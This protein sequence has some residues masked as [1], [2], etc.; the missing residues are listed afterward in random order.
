MTAASL[1]EPM[2]QTEVVAE[3]MAESGFGLLKGLLF[4]LGLHAL[5]ALP[6]LLLLY[7]VP[8]PTPNERLAVEL[9]GMVSNRQT[10][11]KQLGEQVD[12][13]AAEPQKASATQRKSLPVVKQST[14][15]SPVQVDKQDDKPEVQ[16]Q[17]QVTSSYQGADEQQ[18][19]QTI[20][21][22]DLEMDALRKYAAAATKAIK[23][24]LVYPP[25][26]RQAGHSGMTIITFRVGLDGEIEAGTLVV[27][28]SSGYAS[29]DESAL[30]AA[31][32]A[33]PLPP[34][35]RSMSV[36]VPINFNETVK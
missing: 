19:Q 5:L 25:E 8:D 29:L 30:R 14:A 16:H 35:P 28:R 17:Q 34:P 31:R 27:R 24:K 13:K 22:N 15:E 9:F 26:A 1:A 7:W 4:S 20:Q 18:K 23:A 3:D 11:Q 12:H 32:A 21:N 10:E 2:W 33:A 6:I 36:V